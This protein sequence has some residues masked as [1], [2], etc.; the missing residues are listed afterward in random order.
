MLLLIVGDR[1]EPSGEVILSGQLRRPDRLANASDSPA[2]RRLH[3]WRRSIVLAVAAIVVFG[4]AVPNAAAATSARPVQVQTSSVPISLLTQQLSW[5]ECYPGAG[6]PELRCAPVTVPLDWAHPFGKTIKI[7]ISRIKAADPGKRKGV[8]FTNPGGPGAEGLD[9]PLFIPETDPTI[10]A[11][12]DLIGIDQRGVGESDPVL[13]CADPAILNT[14]DNLD[15]RDTSPSNQ[16][17]I[18]TLDQKYARECSDD[19]LT[20]YIQH[21]QTVQ[22]FDLVRQLLHE[23]KINYLGFSGGTQLGAW[24]ASVFPQHVGRFVLD[25]NVDWTSLTYESFDRQPEGFQNSFDNFLEPWIAKYNSTYGLGATAREVDATYERRRAV[26]AKHP[27]TLS[28]GSTLTAAGYDSGI[29]SA[30]YVTSDYPDIAEALSA[31]EHYNTAT[32]AEKDLVTELFADSSTTG[33]DPFYAI[34]C[35]DDRPQSYSAVVA[36]TNYFRT[37]DPLVGANWNVN[38][39]PFF[40]LQSPVRPSKATNCRSCSCSTTTMTPQLLCRTR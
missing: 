29:T 10:A 7:E 26:L 19:P 8:L 16:A 40:T 1:Q 23:D 25:G 22:D 3:L 34:V 6:Y 20:E 27:L 11:A 32:S 17:E 21:S 39:C 12:F 30:L 36:E 35:Q 37:H 13:Q 5:S 31:I 9:L 15:G 4:L 24:Y 28:D 33:N 38:P 2:A 18:K 14:L